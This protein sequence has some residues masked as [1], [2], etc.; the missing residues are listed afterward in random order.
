M[1][2]HYAS[3][4]NESGVVAPGCFLLQLP[5]P[6]FRINLALAVFE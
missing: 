3:L 5:V 1:S 6:H 4:E 2:G